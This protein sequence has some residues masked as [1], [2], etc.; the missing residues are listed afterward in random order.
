MYNA[1]ETISGKG[2]K[3]YFSSLRPLS[4][5]YLDYIVNL[6]CAVTLVLSS[7]TSVCDLGMVSLS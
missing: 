1:Q 3:I 6:M 5:T 7:L 4:P 2:G